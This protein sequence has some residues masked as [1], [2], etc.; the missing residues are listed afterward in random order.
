MKPEVWNPHTKDLWFY[1]AL[2]I[3][4]VLLVVLFSPYLTVLLFAAVVVV[5]SWPI[6]AWVKEKVRGRA[7]LASVLTTL[8]LGLG[9]FGPLS[10][11]AWLFVAEAAETYTAVSTFLGEGTLEA[12]LRSLEEQYHSPHIQDLLERFLPTDFDPVGAIIGPLQQ[13]ASAVLNAGASVVPKLISATVTT[14]LDAI[15]FV[16]AVVTLYVEGPKL[17]VVLMRLSPMD[18]SYEIRLF[19]VFRR[20]ANNM[21]LG[22]LATAVAQGVLA[23]LCFGIAGVDRLVFLGILTAV[24]SFVPMVGSAFVW[25][26]VAVVVGMSSGWGWAIFVGTWS[27]AVTGTADNLIKPLFLRGG[28]N[29]HPLLIFL[30]V[31]GGIMWMGVPG[32][33]VGPVIVAFFLA[34]YTIYLKDYLGVD[35]EDDG[36]AVLFGAMPREE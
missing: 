2:A 14:T 35:P 16:F 28:T 20:F 5:V 22:S 19:Q 4:A 31:F 27:L 1:G 25:V 7:L 17:L 15:L 10:L 26:P 12:W 23:A 36:T 3:S 24:F 30:A 32:A 29:I 33:L 8:L 34:L 21:V 6:H 9:V 13:A 18:D 11:L